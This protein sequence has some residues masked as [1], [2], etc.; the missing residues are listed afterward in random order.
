MTSTSEFKSAEYAQRTTTTQSLTSEEAILA[1]MAIGL[2][3][4]QSPLESTGRLNS[5][6]LDFYDKPL[7]LATN[8]VQSV[9]LSPANDPNDPNSQ[10]PSSKLKKTQTKREKEFQGDNDIDHR[11]VKELP[12]WVKKKDGKTSFRARIREF[13]RADRTP[14]RLSNWYILVPLTLT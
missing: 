8:T 7:K 10:T 3:K 1:N 6:I 9:H 12:A 11:E 14:E 13:T 4:P 5:S 2:D